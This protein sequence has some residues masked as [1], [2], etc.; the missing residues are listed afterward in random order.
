[1]SIEICNNLAIF[2]NSLKKR[3]DWSSPNDGLKF[4]GT[5]TRVDVGSNN[6]PVPINEELTW[7]FC[8]R[9]NNFTPP[10][11]IQRIYHKGT[12]INGF[13]IWITGGGNLAVYMIY[14]NTSIRRITTTS[15]LALNRF[16]HIVIT[17]GNNIKF[18]DFNFYVNGRAFA[19]TLSQDVGNIISVA[20]DPT[21]LT[22]GAQYNIDGTY[23][24]HF[25]G[26]LYDMKIF[27]KVPNFNERME[28]W[29]KQNKS[30][31]ATLAANLRAD[32]RFD[33]RQGT[34]VTDYK[35]AGTYHGTCV[36]Y[37]TTTNLGGGAWVDINGNPITQL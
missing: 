37:G 19:K 9:F 34:N 16:Y 30:V 22:L 23:N 10:N 25:N 36:N 26:I 20:V 33:T 32:W 11:V 15:A 8:I 12:N 17:K 1:M 13:S 5:N 35:P 24:G 4:F 27:N 18:D 6:I 3:I 21:P 14:A 2:E 31:P 7:S 28:L 29:T